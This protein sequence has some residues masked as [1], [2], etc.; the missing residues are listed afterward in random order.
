MLLIKMFLTKKHVIIF[1]SLLNMKE[2]FPY[3]FVFVFIPY[4]IGAISSRKCEKWEFGKK[5]KR[6]LS[7]EGD[8]NFLHTLPCV[9]PPPWEWIR[10][11]WEKCYGNRLLVPSFTF[12]GND[13][14]TIMIISTK[15]SGLYNVIIFTLKWAYK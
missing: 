10:I 13:A 12:C 6:R 15:F 11:L 8:S 1:W 5:M 14:V 7:V 3:D 2:N 4:F 9:T